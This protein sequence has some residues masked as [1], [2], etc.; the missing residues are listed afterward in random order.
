MTG[1]SGSNN[2][3]T[4]VPAGFQLLTATAALAIGLQGRN[5]TLSNATIAWAAAI[6]GEATGTGAA[7][8]YIVDALTADA[9]VAGGAQARVMVLA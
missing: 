8:E 2:N 4:S 7:G 1:G 9:V 5:A 6:T 3:L